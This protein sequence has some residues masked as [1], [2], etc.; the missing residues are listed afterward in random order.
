VFCFVTEGATVFSP[1]L[2]L[3]NRMM[4]ALPPFVPSSSERVTNEQCIKDSQLYL[5]ELRNFSVWAL[6]SKYLLMGLGFTK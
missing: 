6:K 3:A 5:Q 4:S 1:E 2:N